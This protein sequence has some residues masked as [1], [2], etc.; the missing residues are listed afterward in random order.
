MIIFI[1][2]GIISSIFQ[3]VIL[4]EFSFCIAKNELAFILGAGFWIIFC[5]LG[6]ITR[7]PKKLQKLP[8]P[9]IACLAF[10]ISVYLIH[11]AKLLNGMQYYEAA[12]LGLVFLSS[13]TLIGPTAFIT[14]NLFKTLTLAYLKENTPKRDTFA[15]FFAFE[16]LGF[17]LGG[18]AFSLYFNNYTNP[19]I[20]SVLPLFLVIGIKGGLKKAVTAV[21][22]LAVGIISLKTFTPLLQKEFSNARILLNAGSRY[23]P[24]IATRK[25]GSTMIF[26]E[27]SLLATSE[28]KITVE[29]NIHMGLA[30]L[31]HSGEKDIL[32]IGPGLSREIDEIIKYNPGSLD[33][34]HINPLI[35]MLSEYKTPHNI[36]GRVNFI[37]DDPALYLKKTN[38]SYDA[39]L[40]IMPPPSSL[41]LNRYFT[42]D[43]FRLIKAKLKPKGIFSFSMP[44]KREIL[45]PQFA[46]FNSSIINAL[47]KVFSYRLIIPSDTMIITASPGQEIKDYNLIENFMKVNPATDFFTVYHFKDYLKPS[48]RGYI[49]G[50]LDA[51]ISPNTNLNPTGFLNYLILEQ[52]KFYPDFKIDLTR[53]K[54][55]IIVTLLLCWLLIIT[56]S[57]FSKKIFY[58]LNTGVVGFTS[59][60]MTAVIF[61]LFQAYCGALYW[62]LGLL[63]AFF[64]AGLSA[65]ILTLNSRQKYHPKLLSIIFLCW[66]IAIFALLSSLKRIEGISYADIIFYLSSLLCGFLTGAVYPVVAKGLLE[67]RM[68]EEKITTTIYAADLTGAFL[69]TLICGALL[70]PFLGITGSLITLLTLN[71]ALSLRNLWA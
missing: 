9:L 5:S 24:V 20:F 71:L 29:E 18:L 50:M 64:M 51:K 6:S 3:L 17:F 67:S 12:S 63:I 42:E 15:K 38:K 1:P 26:S 34:L 19:L 48:A 39:V 70:I 47:D 28:D 57:F 32:F 30:A 69:G 35:S 54:N 58:L 43:F 55:N 21:L 23:G 45:S 11:L 4:R 61:V 31:N 46:K 16:A 33:C 22:I 59:I 25:A 41:S 60:G 37:T 13:I 8:L 14:G 10:A 27:G 66:G 49:Q 2:L 62:K 53:T 44:S 36:R 7:L 68:K 40:L 65:G 56:A 52:I